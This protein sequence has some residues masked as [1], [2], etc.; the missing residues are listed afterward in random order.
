MYI[1]NVFAERDKKL[2][3][4]VSF[5]LEYIYIYIYIYIIILGVFSMRIELLYKI[6]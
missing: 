6:G 3:K 5:P 2:L 1:L 4:G